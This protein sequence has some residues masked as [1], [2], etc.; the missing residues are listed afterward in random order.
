M[1]EG[2]KPNKRALAGFRPKTAKVS[3]KKTLKKDQPKAPHV[4]GHHETKAEQEKH[5]GHS[6]KPKGK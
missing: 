4:K 2:G 5:K 6:V 3:P 1:V